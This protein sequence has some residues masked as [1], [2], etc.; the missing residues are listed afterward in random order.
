MPV[1]EQWILLT[2][3]ITA[4]MEDKNAEINSQKHKLNKASDQF[5]ADLVRE[6]GLARQKEEESYKQLTKYKSKLEK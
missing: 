1:V 2:H 3:K 6:Q 4:L 5:K